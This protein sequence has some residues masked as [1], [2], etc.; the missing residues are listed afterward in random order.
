MQRNRQALPEKRKKEKLDNL[1]LLGL[2]ED[3]FSK[4]GERVF[5]AYSSTTKNDAVSAPGTYA[6]YAAILLQLRFFLACLLL[7][8]PS[9]QATTL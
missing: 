2:N 9:K 7:S 5:T 4:I 1:N 8:E 6:Y 3:L